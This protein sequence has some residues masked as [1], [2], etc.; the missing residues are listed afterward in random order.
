VRYTGVDLTSPLA[1]VAAD[2]SALPFADRSFDVVIASHVLEHVADDRAALRE[3]RRVLRSDGRA[4][5]L[6][7]VHG[8]LAATLEDPAFDTPELR[9]A[10]YGQSDHV[11]L[12]GRDF[13]RRVS[14]TGFT[15][16]EI[17]MHD[18]LGPRDA[19]RFG[20]IPHDTVFACRPS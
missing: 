13:A 11:R 19:A 4:L 15:V 12:Y 1:A 9:L 16:E 8:G 20:L 14:A 7:P 17:N 5:L 10:N 18:Q 2:I 6:V 3:V